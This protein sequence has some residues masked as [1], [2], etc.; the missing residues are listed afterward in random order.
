MPKIM[1]K[2]ENWWTRQDL[3]LGPTDYELV[4]MIPANCLI[5][6]LSASET[7][8]EILNCI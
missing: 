4:K 7:Y 8:S 2:L 6:L 5:L 3:N 1:S